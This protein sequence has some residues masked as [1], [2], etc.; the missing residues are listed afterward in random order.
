MST[1][2][3]TPSTYTTAVKT[4][5]IKIGHQLDFEAH[6]KQEQRRDSVAS[7]LLSRLLAIECPLELRANILP[8]GSIWEFSADWVAPGSTNTYWHFFMTHRHEMTEAQRQ[9][10][11][12]IHY[13]TIK[14]F[15]IDGC[16]GGPVCT[17]VF[18]GLTHS[19][20]EQLGGVTPGPVAYNG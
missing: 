16:L 4:V 18:A 9:T 2:A 14:L 11:A 17:A 8:D 5:T 1:I 20:A 3:Y 19:Q 15:G 12:A 10:L 7:V 6:R 13:G